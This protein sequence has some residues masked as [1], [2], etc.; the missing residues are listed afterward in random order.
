MKINN[1][2]EV[3]FEDMISIRSIMA[4]QLKLKGPQFTFDSIKQQVEC[5]N[6]SNKSLGLL[7]IMI[8]DEEVQF[9]IDEFLLKNI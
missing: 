6:M 1:A 8:E 5:G 3:P 7:H 9:Q 4:Y 2:Y